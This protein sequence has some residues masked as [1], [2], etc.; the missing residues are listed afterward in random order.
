MP[1]LANLRNAKNLVDMLKKLRPND[2]PPKLIINQAGV[3]K[4]AEISVSDFTEPL[5][6]TPLAVIPFDPVLFGNSANNGRMLGEMD[7]KHP[8]V[9]AINE[10]AHVLTGRTELKPK[11]KQ[12]FSSILGKLKRTKK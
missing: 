5:G 3:P 11:A 10:M 4:R 1:E 9:Q 8:T 12:G 7:A 6:L 2:A